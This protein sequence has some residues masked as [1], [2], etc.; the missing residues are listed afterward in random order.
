[1]RKGGKG[2]TPE[3]KRM[4]EDRRGPL[5]CWDKENLVRVGWRTLFKSHVLELWASR[6]TF[7]YVEAESSS[8]SHSGIQAAL[9]QTVPR[10]LNKMNHLPVQLRSFPPSSLSSSG[11]ER[12]CH[13][14]GITEPPPWKP[15]DLVQAACVLQAIRLAGE[16][17]GG[18][19]GPTS[20]S[21]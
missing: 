17:T 1:M 9:Q 3:G 8:F 16:G 13:S 14:E 7:L 6:F 2:R 18:L 4:E 5:G 11:P 15:R 10:N 19:S 12:D 20:T 21:R